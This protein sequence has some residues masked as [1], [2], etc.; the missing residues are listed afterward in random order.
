M[1]EIKKEVI[2]KNY[3][4]VICDVERG[5][6]IY[7]MNFSIDP[8]EHTTHIIFLLGSKEERT[9]HRIVEYDGNDGLWVKYEING[10]TKEFISLLNVCL[11]VIV[12]MCPNAHLDSGEDYI[13]FE[14]SYYSSLDV[15]KVLKKL[16]TDFEKIA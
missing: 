4:D 16:A 6:Y 14:C 10:H 3:D 15:D 9:F 5:N 12:K 8:C 13:T 11:S 1:L 2:V 7:E